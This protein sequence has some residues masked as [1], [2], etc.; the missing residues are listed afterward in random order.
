[1]NMRRSAALSAALALTTSLAQAQL[2]PADVPA[3][4]GPLGGSAVSVISHPQDADE[5]LLIRYTLGLFRSTD[6]GANFVPHGTGYTGALRDL[7]HDPLV[8][9]TLWGLDG[10]QVVRS[11]D[12]GATWNALGLVASNNLKSVSIPTSGN[13]LLATD[14]FNVYRSTDGGANWSVT[15]SVVPFAGKVLDEVHFAP[16]DPQIAY[17]AYNDGVLRSSDG[18]Q[19]FAQSGPWDGWAQT[20]TVWPSDPNVV[21]VGAYAEGVMRSL[22][23]GANFTQ[24]AIGLTPLDN[25][26][27]LRWAP[28]GTTLWY[29]LLQGFAQSLD[30]GSTWTL[31][32]DGLAFDTPIPSTV[33]FD[34]D[35][36]MYLGTESNSLSSQSG[37]GLYH[38]DLGDTAWTHVAFPEE[39]IRDVAIVGPN[40]QRLIALGSGVLEVGIGQPVT[41]T[42]WQAGIGADTRRIAID[43]SD[44]T[45]WLAGGVGAFQDNAQV[46]VLS[47]SGATA[48]KTYEMFG[49]GRVEALAFDPGNSNVV[50]A[51]LFPA[52][53][54]S[55][56]IIRSTNGGDNWT[57]VG[58]TVGWATVDVAFDPLTPG[59]MIQ[60]SQN[61]QWAWSV[62]SGAAWGPLQPAWPASGPAAFV[63]FDP[64]VPNRLYRGDAGDGLWVT[65]D[66][67]N[68]T[69]L[70]V[71][72]HADS[73]ILLHPHVPGMFWIGS[74]S[75]E[76]LVTTDHGAT[77]EQA[78]NVPKAAKATRMVLDPATGDM[79]LGTT[80]ASTW[81]LPNASPYVSLGG[82]TL[83]SGG[84][85][86]RHFPSGGL[87]RIGNGA[88]GLSGDQLVGGAGVALF[89]GLVDLQLPA[90][91]GTFHVGAQ[92][93]F[94]PAT[95]SGAGAGSGSF[96]TAVPL[97]ADPFLVGLQ[98][99]TQYGAIDAGAPDPSGL[100]LSNAVRTRLL[101]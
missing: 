61:N 83:G 23:G 90:L 3:P 58:G 33:E 4:L 71:A 86:A 18:G 62:D 12:F 78:W 91:G 101:P 1:M 73:E 76:V 66:W 59:R 81:E 85:A 84:F 41:P 50:V 7:Q 24:V 15:H 48:V 52:G 8:P 34:A 74:D 54:G 72:L 38:R 45:R 88:W 6:G 100:V 77:F 28:D 75:G 68:W 37:G 99:I 47:G 97:P 65:D 42:A 9:T 26:E 25:P 96:T 13:S 30:L 2:N 46:V 98:L 56:A 16:S 67:S 29:G 63:A 57:E 70:N 43:P 87:P 93:A 35:G 95:A 31:E 44:P 19:S 21:I 82:G 94:F 51:G 60:L 53:F 20:M 40:G 11:T 36:G 10:A 89:L 22:D 49:A 55:K 39:F 69:K 27:F 80:Q 5:V 79:L 17:V 32:M 64:F 92:V 14:A